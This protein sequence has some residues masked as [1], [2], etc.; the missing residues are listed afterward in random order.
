MSSKIFKI[1]QIVTCICCGAVGKIIAM[2]SVLVTCELINH[3]IYNLDSPANFHEDAVRVIEPKSTN[4][5][6]RNARNM[7]DVT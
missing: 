3:G 4:Y 5:I 2:N 7:P 1:G 6:S